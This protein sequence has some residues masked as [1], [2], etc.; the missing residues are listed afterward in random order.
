MKLL[1]IRHGDPDYA[2]DSL[3]EKGHREAE[4]L[5]ERIAPMDVKAYYISPLGRAGK[6]AEYTLNKAGRTAEVLDWAKEFFEVQIDDGS[7]GKRIAWDLLPENWTKVPEYYD[8]DKWTDVKIMKDAGMREGIERVY[9]GL[10]KLLERHGYKREG[11]IYRA[12]SPNEDTVALFCHFGV[13]CV[14][15]SHLLGISPMVLWHG[16]IAAP[17]SVT[18]LVTE[19][20]REGA[21]AF[22]MTAFGDISHLYKYGEPPAFA[23]RFCEVFSNE[24]QRHD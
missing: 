19:E 23:G 5:S 17:T 3:T 18:T 1:L 10:D 8:M 24:E 12:V 4:L 22:R 2:A 20:R 14:M 13:T 9:N 11:N 7:G 16:T 15:L 6:T 21:A